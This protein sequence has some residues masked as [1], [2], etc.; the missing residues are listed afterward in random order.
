[1]NLLAI[2]FGTKHIGL[3]LSEDGL[4]TTLPVIKNNEKT[5]GKIQEIIKEYS[6]SKIYVGLSEGK[7]ATLTHEFVKHLSSMLELPVE[8][9]EE[10]TSTLE[11]DK[12]YKQIKGKKK[13]YKNSI[14]SVAAAVILRRIVG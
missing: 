2:D 3:A 13:A 10:Q 8:T 12:I 7:I 4:I 9:I 14:D 6:V 1:M 11:A 5:F